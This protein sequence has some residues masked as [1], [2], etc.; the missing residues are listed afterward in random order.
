MH[1]PDMK[2]GRRPA[3]ST[4]GISDRSRQSRTGTSA[5]ARGAAVTPEVI[6]PPQILEPCQLPTAPQTGADV[7]AQFIP[8][9]PFVAKLGIVAEVLGGDEVR[10]RLPWDPIQRHGRRHG[11]R[12]RRS[13]AGRCRGDGRR[14]GGRR[15]ARLAARRD[16]VDVDA[17]S[18]PARATDLIAI[19]RVLRRGKTLVNC[20][21]DV[22]TPAATRS[23]RR[24]RTTRSS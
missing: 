18:A 10:L 8:S 1:N 3:M 9:S 21:V 6:D 23:R 14:V 20:D 19:G 5:S 15:G 7:M 22:V 17:V 24:S 13:C 4:P 12:R 2:P 11:A 16:H